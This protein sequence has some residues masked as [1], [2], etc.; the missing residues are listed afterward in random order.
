MP[1]RLHLDCFS[2]VSGDM[3]LGVLLDLGLPLQDLN[4]DLAKMGFC[5]LRIRKQTVMRAGLRATQVRILVPDSPQPHRDLRH[6]RSRIS[7]TT[8]SQQVKQKAT[9]VFAALAEAEARIHGVSV[10]KVHFHE[11]G[12][13]DAIADVVGVVSGL[14]RMGIS[15]ITCGAVNVGQGFVESAHGTLPVPAPAAL[16]LLKGFTIMGRGPQA[17][18]ATPTGAA[19]L[20]VLARPAA[21]IPEGRLRRIGYGAGSRDFPGFGNCLR[22]WL[23]AG[24]ESAGHSVPGDEVAVLTTNIDDASPQV[25]A[26]ALE[27]LLAAG[28]LDALFKPVMMKKNRPGKSRADL[29]YIVSW[30][31][32]IRHCLTAAP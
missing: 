4:L 1:E 2:G 17:E 32:S 29:D 9:A 18:L 11:V 22:G 16:D 8:L 10:D 25:C 6:I 7:R 31:K 26:Y 19:L 13:L 30:R 23:T 27:R 14:A 5:G 24:E 3:L 21:G 12:A 15:E 28:A 20:R